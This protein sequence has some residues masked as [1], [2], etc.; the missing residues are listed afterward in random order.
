MMGGE[1]K[2]RLGCTVEIIWIPASVEEISRSAFLGCAKLKDVS[3]DS[4]DVNLDSH[5]NAACFDI[6]ASPASPPDA[7][8]VT[9]PLCFCLADCQSIT[10]A[11]ACCLIYKS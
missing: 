10:T 9:S 3:M 6:A 1:G 4:S 11:A 7:D 2:K 5:Q 8:K